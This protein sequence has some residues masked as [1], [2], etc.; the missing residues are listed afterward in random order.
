MQLSITD[1]LPG[2]TLSAN[3]VFTIQPTTVGSY[4][5]TLTVTNAAGAFTKTVDWTIN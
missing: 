5:P 3:G 1:A 4:A 2:V